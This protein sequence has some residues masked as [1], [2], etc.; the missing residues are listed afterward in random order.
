[1][2]FV[3]KWREQR[4]IIE[5]ETDERIRALRLMVL[6]DTVYAVTVVGMLSWAVVTAFHLSGGW[7]AL[8][9]MVAF[10]AAQSISRRRRGLVES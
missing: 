6:R 4:A 8:T 9:C 1:M 5:R 7:V 3:K 10:F 2:E